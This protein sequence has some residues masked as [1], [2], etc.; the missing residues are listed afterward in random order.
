MLVQMRFRTYFKI[1]LSIKEQLV[2]QLNR[3]E[4][5]AL[6]SALL[7]GCDERFTD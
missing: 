6:Q 4:L 5:K 2:E 1:P 3:L 7:E